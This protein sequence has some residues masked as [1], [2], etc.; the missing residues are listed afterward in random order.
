MSKSLE[1][2]LA[3]LRRSIRRLDTA[4]V[5]CSGD[6]DNSF[7]IRIC[8]EELG[9]KAL[10]IMALS[11]IY[12]GTELSLA[13]RVARIMGIRDSPSSDF[14]VVSS[15][16]SMPPSGR[17]SH[18]Y[19]SLKSLEMRTKMG[20]ALG[21]AEDGS[22]ESKLILVPRGTTPRSP[23]LESGVSKAEIRL[24]A[25]ELG[26]PNWDRPVRDKEMRAQAKGLRGAKDYLAA[27]GF[28][29]AC[30]SARGKRISICVKKSEVMRLAKHSDA[31]SRRMRAL[32]F[33]VV[34]IKLL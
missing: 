16:K 14:A 5:A 1:S 13:R 9:E 4:L 33:A 19:S 11:N 17:S 22:S 3:D 8:R 32:G 26:L 29:D 12:P 7:L 6:I 27:L 34:M 28:S 2:K 30:I 18:V 31:I 25:K 24:L 10:S 23:I 15:R 20:N 21:K